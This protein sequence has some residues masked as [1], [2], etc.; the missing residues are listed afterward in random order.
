MRKW[1]PVLTVLAAVIASVVVYPRLPEV[2]PT[3]WDIEGD[4]NGWSSRFWG[5]FGLPLAMVGT[6]AMMRLLPLVDPRRDNY[7][8][9]ENAYEGIV[10]TILVF[11]L[12]VHIVVLRAALGY[13]VSMQRVMP[14]GMGALFIAIGNLLP[15]ARSNFFVGIRT[16]WTLSSE[17]SWERT[18]RAGGY[19][20]VVIGLLMVAASF[21]PMGSSMPVVIGLTVVAVLGLAAYS[22]VVW[23]GD[24]DKR[25]VF[26]A[27]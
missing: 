13:P 24:P 16:P 20:F 14:L 12:G 6:Y 8:K 18:H 11:L 1:I 25:G 10:L 22:Y 19:V 9:F 2:I 7:T 4:V 26:S 27:R 21:F 17:R 15:R 5:A 23:K 3:H